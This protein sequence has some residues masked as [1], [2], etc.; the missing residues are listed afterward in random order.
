MFWCHHD[1][2]KTTVFIHLQGALGY[3]THP[4]LSKTIVTSKQNQNFT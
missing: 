3:K 4:K 2:I 1:A